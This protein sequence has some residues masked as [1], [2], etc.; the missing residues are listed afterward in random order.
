MVGQPACWQAR[1]AEKQ[2]VAASDAKSTAEAAAT[3]AE[4]ELAAAAEARKQAKARARAHV[5]QGHLSR[6]TTSR[7]GH[8]AAC[9]L[10]RPFDS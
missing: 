6:A 4:A 3:E 9:H 1:K 10:G 8:Q 5:S 2:A 7:A